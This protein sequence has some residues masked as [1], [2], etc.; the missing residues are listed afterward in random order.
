VPRQV[1]FGDGGGNFVGEKFGERNH[2][3][4][5]SG[6]EDVLER[7]AH[8]GERE[9]V[10][11]ESAADAAGVAIFEMNAS[12]DFFGDFGGAAVGSGGETAGDRFANDEHVGVE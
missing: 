11:S 9:D 12:G 10:G 6:G 4:E 3:G 5:C 8:G 2:V 1:G 7:G